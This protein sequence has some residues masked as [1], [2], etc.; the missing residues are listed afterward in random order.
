VQELIYSILSEGEKLGQLARELDVLGR[1]GLT[2]L[3]RPWS[4]GRSVG[5]A[6][7]SKTF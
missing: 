6:V 1:R 2:R 5:R 4:L 7:F 3:I